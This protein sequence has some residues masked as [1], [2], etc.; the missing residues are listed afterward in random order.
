MKRSLHISAMFAC[1]TI[2]S[3]VLLAQEK[4][5]KGKLEEELKKAYSLTK[6]VVLTTNIREAGE[7]YN[8]MK[9]GILAIPQSNQHPDLTYIKA[10]K[11]SEAGSDGGAGLILKGGHNHLT[12]QRGD[13]VHITGINVADRGIVFDL[14]TVSSS[15]GTRR[16]QALQ[17]KVVF[18]NEKGRFPDVTTVDEVKK[19]VGEFL[20]SEAQAKAPKTIAMDQTIDEVVAIKGQPKDKAILGSKTTYFYDN[21]KVI[22]VD[23]KVQDVQ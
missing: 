1:V 3:A 17:S 13:K 18:Q 8:V 5:D 20:V 19:I 15:A 10:G 2:A 12:L 21:M 6:F 9:D 4:L 11:A 22:F 14:M 7:V 23:G 16:G